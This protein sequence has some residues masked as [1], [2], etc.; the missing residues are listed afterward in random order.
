[1]KKRQETGPVL[2]VL[3]CA[4]LAGFGCDTDFTVGDGQ[5]SD[6]LQVEDMGG[7]WVSD[8]A[9]DEAEEDGG[10][11]DADAEPVE[12]AETDA[13]EDADE[14]G[15]MA[16]VDFT[17]SVGFEGSAGGTVTSSPPGISCDT[18]CD[19][20]F[21]SDTE[22]TLTA[23]P[24]EEAV[25][26]GWS[27]A[28]SGFDACVVVMD[29]DK[30]VVAA[31]N[32][33]GRHSLSVALAGNGSGTVVSDPGGIDC[34]DDCSQEYVEGSTVTLA[35]AAAEGSTFGGWSGG[36]C[37]GLGNC[38]VTMTE[39]IAVTATFTLNRYTL[40]VSK[41]GSG[42]VRSEDGGIECGDD[43]SQDY[44]HGA[45]VT[46]SAE[47]AEGSTFTGW[48]GGGCGGNGTC[49]VTM[50]SETAMT[51]TFTLNRY[52][53][54]VSLAGSGNGTVTSTP[55]G[56]DC[57]SDCSQ[58]YDFGTS[59]TLSASVVGCSAFI[60]WSGGVCSGPG[61]CMVTVTADMTVTAEFQ[62]G[63]SY[64]VDALTGSDA[65]EGS[66]GFPF[67]TITKALSL[68]AADCTVYAAP[69]TYDLNNDEVFPLQLPEGV[70]LVGDEPNKGAGGDP[71]VIK[72]GSTTGVIG[73]SIEAAADSV[74]AG[75]TILADPAAG[76]TFNMNLAITSNRVTLRN[77]TIV[78][79]VRTGVYIYSGSSQHV[80]EGN[81]IQGN[82]LGLGFIGGGLGSRVE[83]NVITGN[84][85]GV[86]YDSTGGDMGG[87]STGSTGGNILSCNTVNDI[88]TNAGTTINAGNNYWDHVP[89]T[90]S[91]GAG[92]GIDIR[93]DTASTVIYDGAMV[94]PSPCL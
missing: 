20:D 5:E 70:F 41:A 54:S 18:D 7:D 89:P 21:E 85:Y 94:A 84:F 32:P 28:C 73:T 36:G 50:T 3:F 34:G 61:D 9:P 17:L 35:A 37:G 13:V 23:V 48:S 92:G 63:L 72:G 93:H 25:F 81:V 58:A 91:D 46:L 90:E 24:I 79:G 86:E 56:I 55:P 76:A 75:F 15:D 68:V 8:S 74:I 53:L 19:H 31:F 44:D 77:N 57:G 67:K 11:E 71:T 43:C 65:Y 52:T 88:W 2:L 83:N 12:D 4:C 69:G 33:P 30:D 60:G 42:T 66:A 6:E 10:Y 22:V 38:D 47:P 29:S 59:V 80:I 16:P 27:G 62:E 64:Y 49:H 40:S 87:G 78:N 82:N 39:A 26:G 51:A 1:M 14:P 45:S